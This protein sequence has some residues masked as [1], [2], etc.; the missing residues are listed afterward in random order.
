[1]VRLGEPERG[2][3]SCRWLPASRD[4]AQPLAHIPDENTWAGFSLGNGRLPLWNAGA[5]AALFFHE[6]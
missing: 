3:A 6:F 5:L 2:M 4:L 1:M